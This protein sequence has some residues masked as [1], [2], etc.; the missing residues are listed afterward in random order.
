MTELRVLQPHDP[1]PEGGRYMLVLR[2]FGEASP[3]TAITEIITADGRDP[4]EVSVALLPN[5]EPMD[6]RQAVQQAKA[7]AERHG[8][9]VLF[10]VDRTAGPQERAVRHHA[11]DRTTGLDRMADTDPEDGELGTDIRDRPADAGYNL[12]PE[13]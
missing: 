11:G 5:A 12:R 10:A 6:F 7:Q 4:P 9:G 13:R 8:F 2:R 3:R 1:V